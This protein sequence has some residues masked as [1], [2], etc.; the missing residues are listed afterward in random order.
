MIVTVR[1]RKGT[2]TFDET[3]PLG[4]EGGCW[5]L[6][7]G[8]SGEGADGKPVA[9][10]RIHSNMQHKAGRE[11][12]IAKYLLGHSHPRLIPILDVGRDSSSDQNF[13]VMAQAQQRL[14]DLIEQSAPLDES[15]A[16]EIIGAIASG[17]MEIDEMV[18]R[19][20][21]PG[22]VRFHNGVWKISDL[23][24]A[25]YAED[26]TSSN[27]LKGFVSQQYAAPEQWRNEHA[28]KATDVYALGCIIYSLMTGAPPFSGHTIQDYS[29][30]HQFESPPPLP[31]SDRL[32]ALAA[33][34][35]SKAPLARPSLKS[36]RAHLL[37]ARQALDLP[38][39]SRP[40]AVA[41]A[42]TEEK[43]KIEARQAL[44]SK[45]TADRNTLAAEAIKQFDEQARRDAK[46]GISA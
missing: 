45:S 42:L 26:S 20:L 5:W 17:L 30:M 44:E 37:R 14:Q 36:V 33:A 41:A 8:L 43:V 13:I 23:G 35:L 38:P 46:L 22:N 2:W 7:S 9:V 11:L 34:C 28:T 6:R 24:L 3:K 12:D 16:L 31:A 4:P 27:T 18:H 25:R 15:D 10:K 39:S 21:K 32:R 19:D 40:A 1:L 29:R